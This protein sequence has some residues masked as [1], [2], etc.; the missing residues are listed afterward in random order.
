MSTRSTLTGCVFA[1][2]AAFPL[3]SHADPFGSNLIVNGDAESGVGSASGNDVLAV[4][5]FVTTGNFT[6][7][8]YG[9]PQFPTLANAGPENRGLNFFAGGPSIALSTAMQ[10][11]DVSTGAAAI[12]AGGSTFDLSAFLGGF[13]TQDD[14][15]VL[16]ISFLSGASAT[17]GSASIGPTTQPDRGGISGLLFQETSGFVPIGTR[18][19]E[20][21]LT[22][23][24]FQGSYDDGYADNLSL[25]LA[26]GDVVV[27]PPIPEPG[28]YALMLAGLG[29]LGFA[30]RRRR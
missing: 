4:P 8:Q 28:T 11:I 14:N 30:V 19:I 17:L 24:R 21:T 13:D 16:S 26:A 1:L 5:G 22:M 15:A 2:A 23:T 6:A 9:A 29:A 25:V 10:S 3:A 18:S 12:D 7:V 27:P 20:L